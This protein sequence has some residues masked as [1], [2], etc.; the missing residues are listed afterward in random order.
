MIAHIFK[1]E[2][3]ITDDIITIEVPENYAIC[4]IQNQ[5]DKI[6]M[7]CVIDIHAKLVKRHF[8]I[9]GTGHQITDIENLF[10]LRTVKMPNGLVWH[11]FEVSCSE[12]E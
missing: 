2:I 1:Y 9:I 8:K 11:I 3:P 10:F 6:V 5:G 12:N 7:W 4:D